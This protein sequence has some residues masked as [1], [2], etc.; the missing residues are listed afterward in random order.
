[1]NP[2]Q[3]EPTGQRPMPSPTCQLSRPR[4]SH[5]AASPIRSAPTASTRRAPPAVVGAARSRRVR[6]MPAHAAPHPGPPLLLCLPHLRFKRSRPPRRAPFSF[7]PSLSSAHGHVSVTRPPSFSRLSSTPPTESS[8]SS[9]RFRPPLSP[10]PYLG[11]PSPLS[12]SLAAPGASRSHR[13][14][15]L[16]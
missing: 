1:L 9:A 2:F 14:P 6:A 5:P 4:R 10:F 3:K 13:R 11:L 7:S 8:Q 15:S 12:S 16:R